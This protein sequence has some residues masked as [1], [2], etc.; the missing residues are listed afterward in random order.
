MAVDDT[1]D[2]I[3][4]DL[5]DPGV[6]FLFLVLSILLIDLMAKKRKE[7]SERESEVSE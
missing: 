1:D 3:K 7:K 6:V 5:V 4:M 2:G